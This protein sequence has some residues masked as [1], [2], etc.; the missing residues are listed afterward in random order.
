MHYKIATFIIAF[1]ILH[2]L[3]AQEAY[4]DVKFPSDTPVIFAKDL[5]SDGLSN[6][7]F[8]ISPG[9]DEIFFTVQQPKFLLSTILTIK[10][11][12]GKWGSPEVASFS[13]LYRDLEA[14]FSA[15]GKT[16]YF[17][18]DRPVDN[19]DS[20]NDF[21]IWKVMKDDKGAWGTPQHL[22]FIVNSTK[23]EFYP[24]LSK[25]GNLYFTVEADYGKGKEDI[26]MCRFNNGNYEKPISLPEA[27]NSTSYEFNAFVD[28]DEKFI[29]FTSYGRNDD[30]GGGD[31]YISKK[32]THDNWLPAQHLPIE[33]NS[34]GL[35]Y[36]P[37]VSWDKKYFF[38]TSNRVNTKFKDRK[39]K[40][41]AEIKSLLLST[42]NGLDDIYWVKAYRLF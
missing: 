25:T 7:D 5:L 11:R 32:D 27:I 4:P 34:T 20:V 3:V 29:L 28:P 8:T 39:K 18:S 37:F 31:L 36:C 41:Y 2:V 38:F 35:D 22:G 6:R 33:I 17:S 12:S 24:S 10:K 21:D 23:N 42:G 15:D 9:G 40:T 13:G 1:F 30:M 26:V 14:A 16:I 19:K